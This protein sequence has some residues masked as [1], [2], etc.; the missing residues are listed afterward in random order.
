MTDEARE[1]LERTGL[2]PGDVVTSNASSA[3][4]LWPTLSTIGT[5]YRVILPSSWCL[6][7][8]AALVLSVALSYSDDS[9]ARPAA[10]LLVM[11]DTECIGWTTELTSYESFGWETRQ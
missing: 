8:D 10:L 5:S 9:E 11:G 2:R 4:P 7:G 1:A 6:P 3:L